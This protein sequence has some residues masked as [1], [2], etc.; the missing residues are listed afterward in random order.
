MSRPLRANGEEPWGFVALR[1]QILERGTR[2]CAERESRG[3]WP[4]GRSL[5]LFFLGC[6]VPV[7]LFRLLITSSYNVPMVVY[8][9]KEHLQT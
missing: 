2:V 4:A 7:H 6:E 5:H 3:E 8:L 1:R 9:L